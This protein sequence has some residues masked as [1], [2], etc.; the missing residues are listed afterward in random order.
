MSA[1][2]I[3]WTD[4]VWNPVTG[5]TKVSE[6]CRHCYAETVAE[7]FWGK[8]YPPITLH[9]AGGNAQHLRRRFTDVQCHPGRLAEPLGWRKPRRVFVNSMSDLFH[10]AVPD[11]FLDQVFAVM[12]FVPQHTFQVLTKRPERMQE[13][14]REGPGHCARLRVFAAAA[15]FPGARLDQVMATVRSVDGPPAWPLSNVWLGVSCEDQATADQRIPLLLQT[16]AAVRFVSAEPLLEPIDLRY[17]QPHE[18]PVEI[19][20]LSGTHG[21]QRPHRGKN[22]PLDWVIIGGESGAGA[23]PCD[24][25]WIRSLRDQCKAAEVPCFVKQLGANAI[26][27]AQCDVWCNGE[28]HYS[29][30]AGDALI[31]EAEQTPGY[32]TT[33]HRVSRLLRDRRGGDLAEWPEDLRVRKFPEV[34]P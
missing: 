32:S 21:V 25:A 8:Q 13:Y 11:S 23:R 28:H 30:P 12:A 29:R 33:A 31:R 9:V 16:P 3:Q 22:A 18:P 27:S 5:C 4:A 20:A 2:A 10:E 19:D 24:V 17:L 7:R 15:R 26:D 14:F 6:G 34:R 1:T